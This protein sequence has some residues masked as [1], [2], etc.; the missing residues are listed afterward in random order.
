MCT[1]HV[2]QSSIEASSTYSFSSLAI[3]GRSLPAAFMTKQWNLVWN[4]WN[5]DRWR[6][7]QA[8]SK[9]PSEY[10]YKMWLFMPRTSLIE[11]QST[12]KIVIREDSLQ[13]L[14]PFFYK[15]AVSVTN[16]AMA[17]GNK[18]KYKAFHTYLL[19]TEKKNTYK[20]RTGQY[21][22]YYVVITRVGWV[23]LEFKSRI[24]QY[25]LPRYDFDF[26]DRIYTARDSTLSAT[27]PLEREQTAPYPFDP[28]NRTKGICEKNKG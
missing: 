14:E 3:I 20:L 12:I 27:I 6:Q 16:R 26:Y 11:Y 21:S 2:T 5:F 19:R 9:S 23:F 13:L 24:V 22:L 7:Y 15:S 28:G 18:G 25:R 17:T 4:E 8:I 1:T 10:L